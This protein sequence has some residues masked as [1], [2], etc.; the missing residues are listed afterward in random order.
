MEYCY[1]RIGRICSISSITPLLR[2][3]SAS[4]LAIWRKP[5]LVIPIEVEESLN[6]VWPWQ[7]R[8]RLELPEKEPR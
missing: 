6:I 1:E 4:P 3:S 8:L 7:F 5:A 2:Y